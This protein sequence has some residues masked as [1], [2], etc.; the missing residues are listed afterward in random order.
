MGVCGLESSD[1]GWEQVVGFCEHSDEPPGSVKGREFLDYLS[2]CSLSKRT[3]LH[4]IRVAKPYT[5][6]SLT[7]WADCHV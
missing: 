5:Q 6:P 3:P 2:D 4:G 7:T 1:S